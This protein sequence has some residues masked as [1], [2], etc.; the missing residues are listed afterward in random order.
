MTF[1][2]PVFIV[3]AVPTIILFIL[4]VKQFFQIKELVQKQKELFQGTEA[5]N[6]EKIILNSKERVIELEGKTKELYQKTTKVHKIA[7][8]GLH[9]VGMVRFNPFREI[10]GDQ[11][12][13]LALLD[14]NNNGV[15]ITSIYSREGVRTYAKSIQKGESIKHPL[16]EEEKKAINIASAEKNIAEKK[17]V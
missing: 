3:L 11:S 17:H 13:S 2:D 6:L 5:R 9:K 4:V 1:Q 15:T 12:F 7:H 14:G 10:G 8:S 16:T